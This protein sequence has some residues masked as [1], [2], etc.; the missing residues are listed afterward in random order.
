TR[1]ARRGTARG[2]PDGGTGALAARR[3][4]GARAQAAPPRERSARPRKRGASVGRED[5]RELAGRG[6]APARGV[7]LM[8]IKGSLREASLADVVQLIYL[9]RRSGCL[10]VA[11]DL[12]FGSIWF[13]DGW[14]V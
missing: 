2:H 9:G 6:R 13:D 1:G 12:N 10:S 8:A 11:S 7:A 3:R 5:D 4:P 14:I